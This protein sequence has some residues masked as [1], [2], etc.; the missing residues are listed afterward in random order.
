MNAPSR[1]GALAHRPCAL[2][3]R[4]VVAVGLSHH[5]EG[6]RIRIHDPQARDELVASLK[7]AG[8][9][10]HAIGRTLEIDHA[11]PPADPLE[12]RFFLRAW[13]ARNPDAGLELIG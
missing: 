8:C 12:L 2:P 4:P 3:G 1:F 9:T 10:T 13:L 11:E 5:T 6:M 7:D